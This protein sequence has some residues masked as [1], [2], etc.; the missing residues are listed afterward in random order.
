MNSAR[1]GKR[2]LNSAPLS[3]L[4]FCLSL[5]S[6]CG[7][8]GGSAAGSA[9]KR[10]AVR[11]FWEVFDRAR[12]H[13]VVHQFDEAA[14]AYREALELQPR[15]TA[16]LYNLANSE[17]HLHNHAAALACLETLEAIDPHETKPK[18]LAAV[19][20][21]DPRPEGPFD[22]PGAQAMLEHAVELNRE[23]SGPFLLQGR[24]ALLS[25]DVDRADERLQLASRANPLC[26]EAL[27]LRGSMALRRGESKHAAKLFSLAMDGARGAPP[28]AGL[29]G[30]GDNARGGAGY[31]ESQLLLGAW[32]LSLTGEEPAAKAP[33]PLPRALS[34]TQGIGRAP[35]TLEGTSKR[36]GKALAAGDFD[37]DGDVDLAVGSLT[38][39][40]SFYSRSEIGLTLAASTGAVG[41]SYLVTTD[42]DGDSSL[43]LHVLRG[44]DLGSGEPS[45]LF[46]RGMFRFDEVKVPG[47]ARRALGAAAIRQGDCVE[48]LEVGADGPLGAVRV[49]ARAGGTW[50]LS[51]AE[52][53]PPGDCALSLTVLPAPEGEVQDVAV[54]FA[55]SAPRIFR[56]STVG[57]K[58]VK[59]V[60][61]LE[62]LAAVDQVTCLDIDADGWG[63]LVLGRSASF[64]S[65]LRW[66]VH[67]KAD[68]LPILILRRAGRARFEP[69]EIELPSFAC[70]VA[71]LLPLDMDGD[72]RNDLVVLG[73]GP[74]PWRIEPWWVLLHRQDRFV[75]QR[76]AYPPGTFSACAAVAVPG[77][78]GSNKVVFAAGGILPA[79]SGTLFVLDR[80]RP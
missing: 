35:Y 32:L 37:G 78:Q 17:L 13:Y 53:V 49:L 51:R 26:A 74:E 10:G 22:L 79:D 62:D 34:D 20:L 70:R 64:V 36:S 72:G 66:L 43:D 7:E 65:G 73:G 75:L 23:E 47:G 24:T 33:V 6:G 28:P 27:N 55:R 14:R 76:G 29:P 3:I 15:H 69:A 59:P 8:D 12:E 42:L 2:S 60:A 19:I 52:G 57:W 46:N 77:R 11:K 40:V 31:H 9:G 68:G 45:F 71:G 54:A 18:L 25:G 61:G 48:V 21:A 50:S 30:E 5:L 80:G 56:R 44:G 39:Q 1:G 4:V 38:G 58:A 67:G 16:S 41:A 63:D